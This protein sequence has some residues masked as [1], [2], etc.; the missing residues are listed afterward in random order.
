[1]IGPNMERER[2]RERERREREREGNPC[3][4]HGFIMMIMMTILCLMD[5]VFFPNVEVTFGLIET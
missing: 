5:N 4:Q 3:L 2:E 1:M